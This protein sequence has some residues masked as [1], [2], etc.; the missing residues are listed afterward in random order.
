MEK[1]VRMMGENICGSYGGDASYMEVFARVDF[2]ACYCI[3]S[4]SL[5]SSSSL[6][7]SGLVLSMMS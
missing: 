1:V 3:V 5:G 6:T 4:S 2:A 7:F